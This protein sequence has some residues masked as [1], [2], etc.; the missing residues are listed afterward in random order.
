MD[1]ETGDELGRTGNELHADGL[2]DRTSI[3]TEH[4]EIVRRA[5]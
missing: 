1:V 3:A 5:F 2:S 4:E